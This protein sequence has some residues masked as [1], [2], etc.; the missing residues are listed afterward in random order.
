M[1]IPFFDTD[2]DDNVEE[3]FEDIVT[4]RVWRER[5]IVDTLVSDNHHI[6]FID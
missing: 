5:I 1:A 4:V 2:E 6:R 3:C